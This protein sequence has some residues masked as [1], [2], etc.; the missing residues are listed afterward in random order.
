MEFLFSV[1]ILKEN[2]TRNNGVSTDTEE[3]VA[4]RN[5]SPVSNQQR[6]TQGGISWRIPGRGIQE[7]LPWPSWVHDGVTEGHFLC[8]LPLPPRIGPETSILQMFSSTLKTSEEGLS[9]MVTAEWVF[10]VMGVGV[11]ATDGVRVALASSGTF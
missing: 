5:L 2:Q 11:R 10:L 1:F 4:E 6:K 7:L 3:V 8:H 9:M